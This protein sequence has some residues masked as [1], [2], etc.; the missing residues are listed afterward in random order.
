M[1]ADDKM[2]IHYYYLQ[3][4]KATKETKTTLQALL[5]GT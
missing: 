5:K 1:S 3:F 4:M 2:R